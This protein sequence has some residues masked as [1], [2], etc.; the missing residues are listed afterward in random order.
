MAA[1]TFGYKH[2]AVNDVSNIAFVY[3]NFLKLEFRKNCRYLFYIY[4][5]R[6]KTSG[7]ATDS[8][9]NGHRKWTDNVAHRM[10]KDNAKV[11]SR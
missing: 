10:C 7:G 8:D 3:W 1:G 4:H 6:V 2:V 9:A 5:W 11:W